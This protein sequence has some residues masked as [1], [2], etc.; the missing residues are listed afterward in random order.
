MCC[1]LACFSSRPSLAIL[2]NIA[3]A[4]RDGLGFAW[5]DRDRGTVR[6]RKGLK[7]AADVHEWTE[8]L[9]LPFVVHARWA[10]A[11]G[12]S[13]QLTHPF[14]IEA[15]PSLALTG[16]TS[17]A[18]LAHNG[19]VTDWENLGRSIGLQLPPSPRGWS[20][21][22]VI[23]AMVARKGKGV[24]AGLGCKFALLSVAGGLETIGDYHTP[25]EGIL[26]SSSTTPAFCFDWDLGMSRAEPEFLYVRRG[27]RER[28]QQSRYE[29][30][31][32]DQMEMQNRI[33]RIDAARA[34]LNLPRWSRK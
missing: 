32:C 29:A 1:I 15:K 31:W 8:R 30:E 34:R 12:D 11:G 14:P 17:G 18:V 28:S 22:R 4:N 9:P 13:P 21:T 26:A 33:D 25:A 3:E 16:E 6:W 5:I 24:L 23:A 19:H 10:T 27:E 2:T 20:D 7:T